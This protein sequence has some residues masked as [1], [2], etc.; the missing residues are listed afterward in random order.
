MTDRRRQMK[1]NDDI[2]TRYLFGE[3]GD[4]ERAA[5]ERWAAED[6]AHRRE[7]EGLRERLDL[8]A[9]RY[10]EGRFDPKAAARKLGLRP[11][12]RRRLAL[13]GGVAAAVAVCVGLWHWWRE[14][15]RV[16]VATGAGETLE[17]TLPD[18]SRVTLAG[19][20][21][22]AYAA[23]FEE[24]EVEMRGKAYFEVR[25][26]G[27][28]FAVETAAA[29]VE[30][31][32][33]AFQAETADDGTEVCVERG[34]VRVTTGERDTTLEAGMA[35][36]CGRDGSIA[37][38]GRYDA[39]R[40]AWKTRVLRFEGTPLREVVARLNGHYRAHVELPGEWAGLELT[41]TFEDVTL[42]EAL[43][44]INEALDIHL[45]E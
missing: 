10:R 12:R 21:E 8:A 23:G 17:V 22:L 34:R 44:I 15:E 36:R 45:E 33:T 14:P 39:N 19:M 43:A 35:A 6:E 38:S 2:L 41:V 20:T 31:L 37:V 18:S 24:R 26:G 9:G 5:V 3:A 7:L 11:S 42:A 32:G 16:V 1:M 13:W 40:T 29:R 28:P 4:E 25:A 30:V 27:A